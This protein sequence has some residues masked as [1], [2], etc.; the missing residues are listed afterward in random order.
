MQ[1]C[2]R[3]GDLLLYVITKCGLPQ[4]GG[5]SPLLWSLVADSLLKWLSKQGVFAQGFADDGVII[6]VGKVL[7]ILSDITQCML[8]GV[9]K[10]CTDRHLSVNPNKTETI[11]FTRKYKPETIRPIYFY[12]K[13]LELCTQVKYLGVTLDPKLSWKLH[14]EAKCNK[15]LISFHQLRKS[16]ASTWGLTPKVTRWMYT[17]IIR[18]SLT[19]ACVLWWPRVELKTA[20]QQMEHLQRLVCLC[21][22][23]ALRTT[24]TMAMELTSNN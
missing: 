14:V 10:W 24:P 7:H 6:T 9:E 8:R 1:V 11:L 21:I 20:G 2:V 22:T 19:Y 3:V 5:L 12:G 15:A 18:A 4:G 16:V 23:G 17:A 13:E